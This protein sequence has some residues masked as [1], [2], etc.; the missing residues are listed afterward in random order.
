MHMNVTFTIS[1]VGSIVNIENVKTETRAHGLIASGTLYLN[2]SC[3]GQT[4]SGTI[5]VE[6]EIIIQGVLHAKEG[7]LTGPSC[8]VGVDNAGLDIG[9]S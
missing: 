6:Y 5:C 7:S 1:F 4:H 8:I 3:E 2:H 9:C